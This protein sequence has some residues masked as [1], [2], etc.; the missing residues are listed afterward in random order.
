M[1]INK[2]KE[3]LKDKPLWLRIV[4]PIILCLGLGAG[5]WFGISSCATF[6]VG[7]FRVKTDKVEIETN[8]V[9]LKSQAKNNSTDTTVKKFITECQS[10]VS[11]SALDSVCVRYGFNDTEDAKLWLS[12]NG[13]NDYFVTLNKIQKDL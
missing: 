13:Y 6:D 4:L 1:E 2:I 10:A 7:S 12:A 3:W 5:V 11:V 9:H 8:E